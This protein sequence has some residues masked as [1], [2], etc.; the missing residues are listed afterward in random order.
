MGGYNLNLAEIQFDFDEYT[1]RKGQSETAYNLKLQQ[2]QFETPSI[3]TY[4]D[5]EKDNLKLGTISNGDTGTKY[6]TMH[7]SVGN[8]NR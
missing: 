3:L 6:A 7:I 2:L 1:L 4:A 5:S 8:L